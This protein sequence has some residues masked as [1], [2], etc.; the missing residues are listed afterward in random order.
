MFL[1][2]CDMS[3]N[4]DG[5]EQDVLNEKSISGSTGNWKNTIPIVCG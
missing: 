3:I 1:L 5:K 2:K 4:D